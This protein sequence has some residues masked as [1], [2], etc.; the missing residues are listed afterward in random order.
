MEFQYEL[1]REF[2]YKFV[3]CEAIILTYFL[4]CQSL[5]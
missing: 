3:T 4:S 1:S 5:A 2:K